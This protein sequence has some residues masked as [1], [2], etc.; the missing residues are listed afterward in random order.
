M[1][2]FPPPPGFKTPFDK[3]DDTEHDPQLSDEA[4]LLIMKSYLRPEQ[5]GNK[6]ILKF[7]LHYITSRSSPDAAEAAGWPRSKGSYYRARPEIHACIEAIT[8][9]ALMKHGYDASE[10]IERA[11]EIAN[12]DPIEFQ[13]P[14]GS[15]KTHMSQIK[16]E[17]RRAI[18][19]FKAK[20]LFGLDN[21][22]MQ[23]VIGQLIEV[24]VWDKLKGIELLGT[25]KNIFK[26]TTRIEHDVTSNMA[27]MLLESGR[28]ADERKVLM[29]RDVT[30]GSNGGGQTSSSD[31]SGWDEDRVSESERG[32]IGGGSGPINDVEDV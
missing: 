7:I 27:S 21:N 32:G 5:F 14:D 18:K 24:E 2:N 30:G 9:T 26:K 16:P 12:I 13:N 8:A 31:Q 19:K 17:A 4:M 22:G 15:F 29:S 6:Q 11:K 25:E 10:M 28:R 3:P 23:I 20:N 1:S